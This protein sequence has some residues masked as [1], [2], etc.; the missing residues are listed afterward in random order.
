MLCKE[1]S[2]YNYFYSKIGLPVMKI[3]DQDSA[4]KNP[5]RLEKPGKGQKRDF[6]GLDYSLHVVLS[7]ALFVSL[8]EIMIEDR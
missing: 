8:V 7:F 6:D 5:E 2:L 4:H 1:R 3:S